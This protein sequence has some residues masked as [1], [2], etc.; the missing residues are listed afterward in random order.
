MHPILKLADLRGE[1]AREREKQLLK[2][3]K[4]ETTTYKYKNKYID[5]HAY[6][7]FR[8]NSKFN[9]NESIIQ[10]DFV[11]LVYKFTFS[12]NSAFVD[13]EHTDINIY[14]S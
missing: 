2:R 7:L 14:I 5:I 3:K 6:I 10:R 11:M 8:K 12:F 1:Q 13:L 9:K 4:N